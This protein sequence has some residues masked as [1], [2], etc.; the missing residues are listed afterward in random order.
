MMVKHSRSR[1]Q[2]FGAGTGLPCIYIP[3][4]AILQQAG[5]AAAVAAA[6]VHQYPA[7]RAASGPQAGP[8]AAAAP[9]ALGG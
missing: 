2:H 1:M 3:G 7:G 8:E 5:R 4:A 6:V 9:G